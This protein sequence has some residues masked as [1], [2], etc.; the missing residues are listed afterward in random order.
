MKKIIALVITLIL[1]TV[2]F[3]CAKKPKDG[4][5]VSFG[6]TGI[7]EQYYISEATGY[8]NHTLYYFGLDADST[9]LWDMVLEEETGKTFSD[10]VKRLALE[11]CASVAWV[12]EW[13]KDNGITLTEED[14][15][16]VEEEIASLKEAVGGTDEKF[17]EYIN[18][19][20]FKT[21][22]DI[23]KYGEINRL[24]TKG[25]EKLTEKGGK[26]EITDADV[27]KY[28]DEN[29]IAI[30]RIYINTVAEMDESTGQYVAIS[31]EKLASQLERVEA[32][33]QGLKDGDNFDLLYA[34]SD[35]AMQASYLNGIT[36]TRGD[37]P[38]IDYENACFELKVG[39]WK[40]IE[41]ENQG[42]FFIKRVEIPEE[43]YERKSE[44]KGLIQGE[45]QTKIYEEYKDEFL[46]DEEF[47][48]NLDI[49][50]LK[51][52]N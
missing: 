3:A 5:V 25:I 1:C 46:V 8:K 20:G 38:S 18:K 26:Y 16:L 15:K 4:I 50:T 44:I 22:E 7:D 30:K 51:V 27:D 49:K 6:D 14:K 28:F 39:E 29:Y 36:I 32:Y 12:V 35:D 33:E 47:I 9:T 52:I 43:G 23:K 2:L 11:E 42:V 37:A 48:K 45:I 31:E 41:I 34:L 21:L 40:K 19:V 10:E 24:Y 13:A 17:L